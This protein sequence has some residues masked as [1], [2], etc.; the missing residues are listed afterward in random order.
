MPWQRRTLGS[1]QLGAGRLWANC[2]ISLSLNVLYEMV[3]TPY[4]PVQCLVHGKRSAMLIS[5]PTSPGEALGN[6]HII[7]SKVLDSV[8]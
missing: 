5:F 2:F 1:H 4:Y 7:F 8:P 6:P 3:L